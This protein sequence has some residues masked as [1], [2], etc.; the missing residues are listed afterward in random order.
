MGFGRLRET[1]PMEDVST[2]R[3]WLKS[4]LTRLTDKDLQVSHPVLSPGAPIPKSRGD[5]VRIDT[6]SGCERAEER[7]HQWAAAGRPLAHHTARDTGEGPA[8]GLQH[9]RSSSSPWSPAAAVPRNRAWLRRTRAG[10]A[11]PPSRWSAKTL[12]RSFLGSALAQL[13]TWDFRR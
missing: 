1:Q 12:T 13:F 3:K 11:L 9:P 7:P 8:V 5:G 4:C 2:L 10:F 6:D